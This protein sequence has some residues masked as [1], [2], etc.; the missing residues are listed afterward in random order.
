MDL[1]TV[2]KLFDR[3]EKSSFNKI[4]IQMEDVKL[5]LERS[6]GLNAMPHVPIPATEKASSE[7]AQPDEAE[8]IRAPISGVFYVAKEPGTEPFVSSGSQV[9]KGDTVC[10]IE[11]MKTMNEICAPRAGIIVSV[12]A[13]DGQTVSASDALFRLTGDK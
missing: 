13:Q 12:L 7:T 3:A 5:S 1:E 8:I 10:I 9:A 6:G 2:F 11:A 4:E